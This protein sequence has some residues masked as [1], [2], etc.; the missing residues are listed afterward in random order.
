MDVK[1]KHFIKIKFS[2][3]HT[4]TVQ[5]RKCVGACRSLRFVIKWLGALLAS[6][7]KSNTRNISSKLIKRRYSGTGC[8]TQRTYWHHTTAEELESKLNRNVYLAMPHSTIR[9]VFIFHCWY[10]IEIPNIRT[11]EFCIPHLPSSPPLRD[12]DYHLESEL[13]LSLSL[14]QH[15]FSYFQI[16][17]S[18]YEYS[19]CLLNIN[20][21]QTDRDRQSYFYN[22]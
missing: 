1:N 12:C 16:F 7:L 20:W 18:Q 9:V 10:N 19:Q 4:T 22:K 15:S 6:L 13:S 14:I 17:N 5:T 11:Q 21:R 3:H 2:P 8:A